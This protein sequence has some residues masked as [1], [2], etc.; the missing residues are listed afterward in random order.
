MKRGLLRPVFTVTSLKMLVMEQPLLR[1]LPCYSKNRTQNPLTYL[2]FICLP[3]RRL[4]RGARRNSQRRICGGKPPSPIHCAEK[5][6]YKTS[7][8]F[9][10]RRRSKKERW[11]Y[12][13]LNTLLSHTLFPKG[14]DLC[15][16]LRL[17]FFKGFTLF[18]ATLQQT[19]NVE[20][21]PTLRKSR[22]KKSTWLSSTAITSLVAEL[23]SLQ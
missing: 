20:I 6:F 14:A 1:F 21:T 19:L 11:T 3:K 9:G 13:H 18:L 15:K 23:K 16:S 12:V 17:L 7:L 10:I 5:G 8:A 22:R 2:T 4:A